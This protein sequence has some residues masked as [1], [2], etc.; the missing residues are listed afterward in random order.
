MTDGEP[1]GEWWEKMKETEKEAVKT[2]EGIK[3][4]FEKRWPKMKKSEDEQEAKKYELEELRLRE[5]EIGMKVDYRGRKIPAHCA[6]AAKALELGNE[7][8]DTNG[9]LIDGVRRNLPSAIRK[10]IINDKYKTW[11][12]FHD[13][14][15]SIRPGA[16]TEAKADTELFNSLRNLMDTTQCGWNPQYYGQ[17]QSTPT[18]VRT[19]TVM[20]NAPITPRTQITRPFTTP[21]T[22]QTMFGTPRGPPAT[23]MT[24]TTAR[25]PAQQPGI[26][27][28]ISTPSNPFQQQPQT[29]GTPTPSY[30]LQKPFEYNLWRPF[31]TSPMGQAAYEK[32]VADWRHKYSGT[33]ATIANPFP[34]RPGGSPLDGHECY[35]CGR[36]GH[37][38]VQCTEPEDR[39]LPMEERNWRADY[40]AGCIADR[41]ANRSTSQ[42]AA[43]EDVTEE[44]GNEQE[45]Q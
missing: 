21:S 28:P 15:T 34:L 26:C 35:Q 29:P 38:G 10:L 45:S 5:E 40:S 31:P 17:T 25:Q 22:S 16:I 8:G 9:L 7:V 13:G 4:L 33:R 37:I 41:I 1:A 24:P 12:E 2:L 11:Q 23:P 32:A 6:F 44:Q 14:I 42:V 27:R 19:T 43:I 3:G 36:K 39:R 30:M 20:Q 18:A